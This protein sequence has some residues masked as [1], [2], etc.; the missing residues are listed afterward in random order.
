MGTAAAG[1]NS[2]AGF[3]SPI[4]S[5]M[6]EQEAQTFGFRE[7]ALPPRGIGSQQQMQIAMFKRNDILPPKTFNQVKLINTEF[8]TRRIRCN[9]GLPFLMDKN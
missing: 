9:N 1:A 6:L 5:I 7:R 8:T 3:E 2:A 4:P